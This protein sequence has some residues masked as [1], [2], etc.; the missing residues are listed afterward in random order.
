MIAVLEHYK[1]FHKSVS[2][3]Y[4]PNECNAN[5]D[6]CRTPVADGT[7][8]IQLKLRASENKEKPK[9]GLI[10]LDVWSSLQGKW[11]FMLINQGL[12]EKLNC[13]A[14]IKTLLAGK[15]KILFHFEAL[16]KKI[17]CFR[18]C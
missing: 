13:S 18:L 16:C 8:C 5:G 14:L 2:P 11:Y 17:M 12:G 15:T 10:Y 4:C 6:N 1:E 9:D 3:H 7:N